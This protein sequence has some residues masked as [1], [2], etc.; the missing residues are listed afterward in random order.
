MT[1]RWWHRSMCPQDGG[2]PNSAYGPPTWSSSASLRRGGVEGGGGGWWSTGEGLVGT[3]P[4]KLT[5]WTAGRSLDFEPLPHWWRG[6][7]GSLKHIH[8]DVIADQDAR[9]AAYTA[10]QDDIVGYLPSDPRA[11]EVSYGAIKST[12]RSELYIRPW[13]ASS[14]IGYPI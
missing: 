13:L 11:P 8:A 1:T 12:P 4:F 3:G 10:G 14:P 9:A 6:S 5:R 7:A 2:L